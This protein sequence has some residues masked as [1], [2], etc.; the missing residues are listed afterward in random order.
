M[1][2]LNFFAKNAT[3]F[4]ILVQ[5][6]FYIITLLIGFFLT[7]FCAVFTVTVFEMVA[8]FPPEYIAGILTGQSVCGII[9]ALVQI[10]SLSIGASS[11]T[12]GLVYFLIGMFFVFISLV[13]YLMVLMKSE[14]FRFHL[15]KVIETGKMDFSRKVLKSVLSKVKFYL[16]SMI[17]VLGCSIIMHPGVTS[18][19]I[20]KYKGNGNK[21]NGK[22]TLNNFFSLFH[23]FFR[24]IFC[25]SGNIFIFPSF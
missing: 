21:W 22:K 20:S 8:K 24:C 13:S 3:N 25:T 10:F 12:N 23:F 4:F 19:V 1:H 14:F 18:L 2:F 11:K 5:Y 9:A 15:N 7:G 16:L 6:T 17:L